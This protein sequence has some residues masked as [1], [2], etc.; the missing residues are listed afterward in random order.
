MTK[1]ERLEKALYNWINETEK[2]ETAVCR[3]IDSEKPKKELM[4]IA[5]NVKKK[6]RYLEDT[7]KFY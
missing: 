4:K 7:I 3:L 1:E 5:N 6:F 2:F